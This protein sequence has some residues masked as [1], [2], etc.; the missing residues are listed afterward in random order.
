MKRI[1]P[2]LLL[3]FLLNSNINA[4][5]WVYVGTNEKGQVTYLDAESIRSISIGIKGVWTKF[6]ENNVRVV[7]QGRDI[8]Y[9]K[10]LYSTYSEY[11]CQKNTVKHIKLIV[12]KTDNSI[13]FSDTKPVSKQNEE[14]IPKDAIGREISKFLCN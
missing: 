5:R 2:I 6:E 9:S 14:Y 13:V 1:I 11:N 4:Q 12:R 7:Q 10:L 3:F 8:T